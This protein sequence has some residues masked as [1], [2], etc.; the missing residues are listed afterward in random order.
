MATLDEQTTTGHQEHSADNDAD[1]DYDDGDDNGNS[2]YADFHLHHNIHNKLKSL[3][4]VVLL[5][6]HCDFSS[7]INYNCFVVPPG[8]M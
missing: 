6:T 4:N 7:Y 1:A 2:N 8:R 3:W 5:N